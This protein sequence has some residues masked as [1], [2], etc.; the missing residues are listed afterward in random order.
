MRIEQGITLLDGKSG[1]GKSTICEAIYFVLYGGKKHKN[2]GMKGESKNKKTYVILTYVSPDKNY[3][4]RRERPTERVTVELLINEEI[5]TL[6]GKEADNWISSEYGTEEAW[7]SSSY[8]AQEKDHFFIREMNSLKRELLRQ[9]TFGDMS[10][11]ITPEYF[12]NNLQPTLSDIKARLE[13]TTVQINTREFII[14]DIISKTPDV[15]KYG[16]FSESTLKKAKK[17]IAQIELLKNKM[18]NDKFKKQRLDIL[19]SNIQE[20]QNTIDIINIDE[21]NHKLEEIKQIKQQNE[22]KNKLSSFDKDILLFNDTNEIKNNKKLYD[23]YIKNGLDINSS[24]EDTKKFLQDK[25]EYLDKYNEYLKIKE[26]NSL[27]KLKNKMIEDQNN[28]KTEKYKSDLKKYEHYLSLKTQL[29]SFDEKVLTINIEDLF[30]SKRL[31]DLYI[32]NGYDINTNLNEFLQFKNKIFNEYINQK[33]IEEENKNIKTKNKDN[34]D[35]Y[36]QKIII[37]KKLI[38]E[39]E[40]YELKLNELNNEEKKL[41]EYIF[42]IIDD[43]DDESCDYLIKTIEKCKLSEKE[44]ICPCCNHGIIFHNGKLIKG[45]SQEFRNNNKNLKELAIIELEKRKQRDEYLKKED[46]FQF[47]EYETPKEPELPIILEL[48]EI[49]KYSKKPLDVFDLP[50]FSYEQT[51]LLYKSYNFIKEYHEFQKQTITEE[52]IIPEYTHIEKVKNQH[53][54]EKPS[55]HTFDIPIYSYSKI[56]ELYNS[57]DLIDVYNNWINNE[58]SNKEIDITEET[59]IITS[60]KNYHS[61]IDKINDRKNMIKEL[62][63]IDNCSDED[64]EV[65]SKKISDLQAKI[66][67]GKV[68]ILYQEHRKNLDDLIEE[69]LQLVEDGKDTE[70][71]IKFIDMIANSSIE[72]MIASINNSLE[73]ITSDLF[74]NPINVVLSTTRELKNGNE[75]NDINIDIVY[76][77]EKYLL[78]ELSGGERKRISFALLVSLMLI[79]DS[80]ICIMDEVLPSMEEDLKEKS[81]EILSMYTKGRFIFHICHGI[82]KGLHDHVKNIQDY[83]EEDEI[84]VDSNNNSDEED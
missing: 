20:Y 13:T 33:N 11:G 49:Q 4:I 65:L 21:L 67:I 50:V 55:L 43:E 66:E 8:L 30:N 82:T 78:N 27:I 47:K 79:N 38:K 14:N 23:K 31:F 25:K 64:I 40:D 6:T 60:I 24:L 74:D 68:A 77:G 3:S 52:P 26:E 56:L 28:Q 5:I 57:I 72:D 44:L 16:Y 19:N 81:L 17:D 58:F 36:N 37:F 63:E 62:G 41:T 7:V 69:Q 80:P 18:N 54:I 12:M 84:D 45:V 73:V 1:S 83:L 61:I 10:V 59:N 42:N 2:I 48:K 34:L 29:K 76:K 75:K 46:S 22:I 15:T 39:K 9:I 71:M 35:E 32:L 51:Q 53:I 70:D